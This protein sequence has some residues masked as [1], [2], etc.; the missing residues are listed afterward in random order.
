M[1]YPPAGTR[2]KAAIIDF[3]LMLLVFTLTAYVIDAIGGAPNWLRASIF[4]LM[5]YLYDPL[6]VG[7]RGGTLGHHLLG[8]EVRSHSNQEK[9]INLLIATLRVMVKYVLGGISVLVSYSRKDHRALHD[10]IC[11]SVVIYKD[12]EKRI[13]D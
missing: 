12:P 4:V 5:V 6:A 2:V 3:L 10:L 11:D 7:L 13:A 1:E 9:R 8:V